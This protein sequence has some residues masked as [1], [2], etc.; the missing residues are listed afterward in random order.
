M[1]DDIGFGRGVIVSGWIFTVCT[2]PFIASQFMDS[3]DV[4]L[5]GLM[6]GKCAPSSF[7]GLNK[8]R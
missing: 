3:R 4:D 1:S 5:V 2:I 7:A 8:S 6:N